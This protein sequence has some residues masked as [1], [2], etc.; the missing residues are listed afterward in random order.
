MTPHELEPILGTVHTLLSAHGYSDAADVVRTSHAKAEQTGYDNWNGG[1]N[2]W[3]VTFQIPPVEY[4]KL[5]S[6]REQIE[7]QITQQ[8]RAVMG[9]D[10]ADCYTAKIMPAHETSRQWRS[11]PVGELQ[12]QVRTNI[13]D[14][15]RLEKV[16]WQGELNDVE[17][18]GRIYELEKL[19]SGDTRFN[20][21]AGDIWQ[22]CVNNDDWDEYW[23]FG[24]KRFALTTGSTEN[25]LRFLCETVHPIVRPSR[26]DA[27]KLVSDYND[28]LRPAGWEIAEQERIGGRPRFDYRPVGSNNDRMMTRGRAVADA[29]DAGAMAREIDRLERS[30]NDDPDLAIGTAKELVESCCKTILS[31]YGVPFSKSSD[32][33]DLTKLTLK[34]LQLV[35]DGIPEQA[36]GAKNIKVILSSLSQLTN[37][38]AQ[39]RGLYGTGHGPN[40]D[41]RGL[42]PRHARLA[43]AGAIA[44]VDFVA[45]TYRHRTE[46]EVDAQE[47]NQRPQTG[48]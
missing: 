31:K 40:G 2:L 6:R 25:F 19:P 17:F 13:F 28:Q 44:F 37:N 47:H 32:I 5:D 43:A 45:D 26:D 15:M 3:D 8:L 22:H 7:D 24:D 23:V 48:K 42:Q 35:P 1:I 33:N 20:N 27:V 46:V 4:A 11:A 12:R 41:Y 34:Q 14:G 10:S 39:L 38:L 16:K 36:K 9:G 29:M 30:V 21:A 18:L